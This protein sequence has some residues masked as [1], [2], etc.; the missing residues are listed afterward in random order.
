MLI[1]ADGQ[2]LY[3][4]ASVVDDT[5]M[6]VTDVVR[7]SD[8]VTNTATQIQIIRALGGTPPAFAHHSLL[9]GPQ[10]EALSKRLGTLALRDLRARGVQPMALLS[11][12]ARLGSSDPVEIALGP[13]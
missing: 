5:E 4:L 8:H 6:G 3:T 10:G 9:T 11:L 2:V 12:M 13:G 1:K 7:G